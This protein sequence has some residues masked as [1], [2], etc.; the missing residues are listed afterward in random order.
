MSCT[1]GAIAVQGL[2]SNW[3]D[4]TKQ[5]TK[6]EEIVLEDP[7]SSVTGNWWGT[8]SYPGSSIPSVPPYGLTSPPRPPQRYFQ[9]QAP[10]GTTSVEDAVLT[11]MRGMT[12]NEHEIDRLKVKF[13]F[14]SYYNN[15]KETIS[16]VTQ[17]FE[18]L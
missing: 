1:C 5:L 9:L 18:E 12:L 16:F 7:P 3:C 11:L 17:V 4:F 8:T 10:T 6:L 2:H 14:H 13:P 15:G